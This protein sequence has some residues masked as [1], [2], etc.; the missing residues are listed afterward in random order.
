MQIF[1]FKILNLVFINIWLLF[2]LK[3]SSPQFFNLIF[4]IILI[5][6]LLI[7]N[8]Q[9]CF[10]SL[11]FNNKFTLILTFTSLKCL[12]SPK[13]RLSSFYNIFIQIVILNHFVIELT[14]MCAIRLH[15][16]SLSWFLKCT[17]RIIRTIRLLIN[18]LISDLRL[19]FLQLFCLFWSWNL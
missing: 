17:G 4:P 6:N 8:K 19:F 13:N 9:S 14:L 11:D 10:Q 2:K 16:I 3:I 15:W 1:C 18:I 7:K 12:L 5:L